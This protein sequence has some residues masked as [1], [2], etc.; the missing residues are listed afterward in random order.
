MNGG[1]PAH[2]PASALAGVTIASL[3]GATAY[4]WWMADYYANAIALQSA[5]HKEAER[6]RETAARLR[7]AMEAAESAGRAKAAFLAKMSHELR[8]PLNAVIGYST[9]LLDDTKAQGA[10]PAMASDLAHINGAG[11]HLLTLVDEVLDLGGQQAGG[12]AAA[13]EPFDLD[14]FIEDLLSTARP[15]I[16]ANGNVLEVERIGALGPVNTDAT[17]LRQAVLNLIGNAAKFTRHGLVTLRV[18]RER[19]PAGDWIV[20]Q[21]RDTGIG[22]AKA[23]LSRLFRDFEQADAST[24][25]AFG[26]AGLGLAISQRLCALMGGTITAESEIGKG[27]AFTIRIPADLGGAAFAR[28]PERMIA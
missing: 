6:H 10:N 27:A 11:R 19:N 26:G 22:V 23:D 4:M 15:L 17:K 14:V 16:A 12:R 2:L 7:R 13:R 1:F 5:A 28:G 24:R 3:V 21:V 25:K 18:S 9:L 8:T 20:L